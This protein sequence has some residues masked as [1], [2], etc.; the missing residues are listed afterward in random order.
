MKLLALS[1]AFLAVSAFSGCT[2]APMRNID[3]PP[4]V[5][6]IGI[7]E[8]SPEQAR[9]GIEAAYSQFIDVRTPEEYNDGHAYRAIN[10]PLDTLP[11]NLGRLEKNEPVFVICRTDNRSREAAKLLTD[12]GFR[13]VVVIT[14]GMNR[15]Q[16]AGMPLAR[17]NGRGRP[18]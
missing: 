4:V 7:S 1:M 15:W 10:I 11:Q 2:T 5:T 13:Q 3:A 6:K 12:A 18:F 8:M 16:A 9:P 14:G 17:S